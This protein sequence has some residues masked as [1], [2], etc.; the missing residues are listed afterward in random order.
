M[1]NRELLE[2]A[3]ESIIRNK[4]YIKSAG[5]VSSVK[6]AAIICFMNELNET[7]NTY[8]IKIIR[9]ALKDIYEL[10]FFNYKESD[11]KNE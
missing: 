8:N 1:Y 11:D 10:G 5:L 4:H 6:E 7:P 9:E 3:C 2:I